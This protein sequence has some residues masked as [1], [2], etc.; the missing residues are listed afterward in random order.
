MPTSQ[1]VYR[2]KTVE[3]VG[4]PYDGWQYPMNYQPVING[5]PWFHNYV[6]GGKDT[7]TYCVYLFDAEIE[8][9]IFEGR[10]KGRY[11]D[12]VQYKGLVSDCG[13]RVYDNVPT[14]ES[15]EDFDGEVLYSCSEWVVFKC[16][17]K[18]Q[19]SEFKHMTSSRLNAC[20]KH[21][22]ID[23]LML[24]D[25]IVETAKKIRANIKE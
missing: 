15:Q 6:V 16:G 4:G 24:R 21:S 22:S 2:L 14:V 23:Q 17:C 7:E 5:T 3:F 10:Y 11:Q 25:H 18:I 8:K 20:S 1:K 12:D 19:F 9:M 13:E